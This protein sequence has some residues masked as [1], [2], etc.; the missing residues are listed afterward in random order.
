MGR[1]R[2]PHSF[3]GN[4]AAWSE[5]RRT[6]RVVCINRDPG[7]LRDRR[8]GAGGRGLPDDDRS[9]ADSRTTAVLR[10]KLSRID[11]VHV[12]VRRPHHPSSR[13][14]AIDAATDSWLPRDRCRRGD[15]GQRGGHHDL[16][17]SGRVIDEQDRPQGDPCLWLSLICERQ[18]LHVH[19]DRHGGPMGHP[20]VSRIDGQRQRNLL[21]PHCQHLAGDPWRGVCIPR[22]SPLCS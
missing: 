4:V 14:I 3:G 13:A 12:S 8:A 16:A 1:F 19:L 6:P 5:S 15:D 10:Q 2:G 11:R 18:L 17:T 20:L 21:C 22:P 7:A 9:A